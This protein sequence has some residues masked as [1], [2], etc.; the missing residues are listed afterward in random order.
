[1]AKV[2]L[3]GLSDMDYHRLLPHGYTGQIITAD[4]FGIVPSELFDLSFD[5]AIT[6]IIANVNLSSFDSF[7]NPSGSLVIISQWLMEALSIARR[8]FSKLNLAI[9]TDFRL[10]PVDIGRSGFNGLGGICDFAVVELD[11]A[12]TACTF[13]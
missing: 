6:S 3:S 2:S 8:R 11:I 1:M 9:A 12:M 13:T 4:K 10:P 7:K 5:R